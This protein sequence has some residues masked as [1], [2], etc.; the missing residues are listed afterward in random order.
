[1]NNSRVS[2]SGELLWI[3]TIFSSFDLLLILKLDWK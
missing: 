2:E 3:G 1:M